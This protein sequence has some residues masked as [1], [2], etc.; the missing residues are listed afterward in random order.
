MWLAKV[1]TIPDRRASAGC[2]YLTPVPRSPRGSTIRTWCR[3]PGWCRCWRWRSGVGS[4]R[5]S[6]GLGLL[7]LRRH[8]GLPPRRGPVLAGGQHRR[9]RTATIRTQLIHTPA[10]IAHSAHRQVL[11]LPRDWP[12]GRAGRTVPP[13]PARP[14]PRSRLTTRPFTGPTETISGSAGQTG[15]STTPTSR[16]RPHRSTTP[17]SQDRR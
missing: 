12:G 7:R 3:V 16:T 11:H 9:T 10:R 2:D 15:G 6:R 17:P 13:R 1:T 8:R 4:R 5:C 14:P